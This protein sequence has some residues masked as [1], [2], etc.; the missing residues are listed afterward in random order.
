MKQKETYSFYWKIYEILLQS[1]LWLLVANS[2][3]GKNNNK[4]GNIKNFE[5]PRN[6]DELAQQHV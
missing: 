1:F 4:K 5:T 6:S 3:I 2:N